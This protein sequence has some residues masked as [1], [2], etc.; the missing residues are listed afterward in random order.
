MIIIYTCKMP[1]H[2]HPKKDLKQ[3]SLANAFGISQCSN[4]LHISENEVYDHVDEDHESDSAKL[5]EEEPTSKRYKRT[6]K[7]KWKMRFPWAYAVKYC[8]GVERIKCS[9]CVKFKRETPFAKDGSTTLQFSAL[10]IHA[11]SEANKFSL[12]LLEGERK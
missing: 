7:S 5:L 1:P 11:T 4:Q 12:Q 6:F 8:N 2:G 10:N 3:R 9:W